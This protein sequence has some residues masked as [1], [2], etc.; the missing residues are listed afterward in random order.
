MS[1]FVGPEPSLDTN[2]VFDAALQVF[3]SLVVFRSCKPHTSPFLDLVI[4]EKRRDYKIDNNI[5]KCII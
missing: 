5:Q 2:D 4:G 1:R 3:F